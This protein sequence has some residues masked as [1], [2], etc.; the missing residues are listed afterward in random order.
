MAAVRP[1]AAELVTLPAP[2]L[3]GVADFWKR[4]SK[5]KAGVF[6]AAAAALLVT[7]ALAAPWLAP[8]PSNLQDYDAIMQ[9][10]SWAHWFGTDELGRDVLSRVIFGTRVSLKAGFFSVAIAVAVGLPVGLVSGYYRGVWDEM[11]LMRVVDAL[12]AFPFLILALAM[13]AA[14]G[15]GLGNAIIAIGI[16]FVPS[17]IRVVRA[18]VMQVREQEFIAAA[19]AVGASDLRIL[20]VHAIPNCLGP[21]LVQASL[22]VAAAIIAEAGLSYLGLG[23]QPP[24]PSWG[25]SLRFAQGY[26]QTAPWMAYWPGAAIFVAVLAFNLLGDGLRDALDPRLRGE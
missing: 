6:G 16:G 12:Q 26:L 19:R 21:V 1:A 5:N 11:V 24:D 9:P 7:I 3:V 8:Y 20:F 14:L 25:S 2:R 22:A 23:V 18:Q 10:P 13:V 17:V 15:P 4:F